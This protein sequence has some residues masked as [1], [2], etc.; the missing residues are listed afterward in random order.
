MTIQAKD[1]KSDVDALV[2]LYKVSLSLLN[3]A[4]CIAWQPQPASIYAS[5]LH[6]QRQES[7]KEM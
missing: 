2:E 1:C 3:H 4:R 5:F 6:R 7:I